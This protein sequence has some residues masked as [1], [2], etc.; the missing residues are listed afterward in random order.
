MTWGRVSLSSIPQPQGSFPST[1]PLKLRAVYGRAHGTVEQNHTSSWFSEALAVFI[2][3]EAGFLEAT[4]FACRL[5]NTPGEDSKGEE[6]RAGGKE[7]ARQWC[8]FWVC[9]P[10]SSQAEQPL[11]A[12]PTSRQGDLAS[13]E[14][15]IRHGLRATRGWKLVCISLSV[16]VHSSGSLERLGK[17]C[18][19]L[20]HQERGDKKKGAME[21]W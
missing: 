13:M 7:G 18:A 8:G 3:I 4:C 16:P 12:L 19:A 21:L 5:R 20:G 17:A 15:G 9:I 11:R 14:Y 1:A 2:I 6:G 10:G